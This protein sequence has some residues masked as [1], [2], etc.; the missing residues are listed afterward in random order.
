MLISLSVIEACQKTFVNET[1]LI[2]MKF[3][4]VPGAKASQSLRGEV[5]VAR[6]FSRKDLSLG[7]RAALLIWSRHCPWGRNS[8]ALVTAFLHF[9]VSKQFFVTSIKFNLGCRQGFECPYQIQK[10]H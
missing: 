3:M 4:V 9:A 1:G 2:T 5:K 7:F 8:R 10:I 6:D